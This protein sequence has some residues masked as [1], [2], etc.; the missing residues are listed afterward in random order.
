MA[1]MRAGYWIF[2]VGVKSAVLLALI[3]TTVIWYVATSHAQT[4]IPICATDPS[5]ATDPCLITGKAGLYF[6]AREGVYIELWTIRLRKDDTNIFENSARSGTNREIGDRTMRKL[7][8][9]VWLA[10]SA[11][12]AHAEEDHRTIAE[13]VFCA[14]IEIQRMTARINITE[15]QDALKGEGNQL[16]IMYGPEILEKMLGA[17]DTKCSEKDIEFAP[18]TGN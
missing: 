15:I 5:A 12:N 18:G 2:V 14:G 3:I 7:L 9:I 16:Y 4:S 8:M 13:K 10:F 17:N 6:I 1:S 11:A